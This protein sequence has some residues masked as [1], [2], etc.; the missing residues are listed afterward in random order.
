MNDEVRS[1]VEAG[2]AAH[3][4][5]SATLDQVTDDVV[6]QPSR[7][8]GWTVGHVLT[9]IA[10][11]ADSIV[12]RIN[13]AV[14]DEVVDQYEGGYEG[15][16][17]DIEAGSAR[18][19]ADIVA[20]VR[21]TSAQVDEAWSTVPD[22]AWERLTRSVG[23][24]LLPLYS[25]PF[26]RWREVEVHHADLGLGYSYTNWPEDYVAQE[27]ARQLERL[28]GRIDD[29][30]ARQRLCAWLMG[31]AQDPGPLDLGPWG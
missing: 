4:R 23:G 5:L 27:L 17:A 15:R 8:E 29:G 7:L 26:S 31:R 11:N 19:A 9:H 18:S 28:P 30:G 3:A 16:A 20:D 25:L 13:G 12:R 6:R 2:R 24:R 22:E 14:N 21:A 1:Q 10:R